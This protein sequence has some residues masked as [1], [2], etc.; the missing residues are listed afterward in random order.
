MVN[1]CVRLHG[2]LKTLTQFPERWVVVR[3]RALYETV[4]LG[5]IFQY[6]GEVVEMRILS[7]GVSGSGEPR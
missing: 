5:A 3:Q 7:S 6:V 2:V 4:L 1:G